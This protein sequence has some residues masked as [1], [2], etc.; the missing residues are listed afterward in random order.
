M[1][2]LDDLEKASGTTW[3]HVRRARAAAIA[4]KAELA[5]AVSELAPADSTVA[6]FGSL[7]RHELTTGSDIDWTLLIDGQANPQHF[8]A[9]LAIERSLEDDLGI[10]PPGRE[11]TFGGLAFSHEILHRIGGSDDSNRNTTQRILLLLESVPIG[12]AS[13]YE[14]VIR[15][16]L[17]RY[18]VEDYGW[19]H[20]SVSVPRFLQNDIARYWRTV[21]IDFAYKRRQRSGSGW[22]LRTVKLRLSRKLTYASGLLVCFAPALN[23]ANHEIDGDDSEAGRTLPLVN[24]LARLTAQTPLERVALAAHALPVIAPHCIELIS[25][26]DDFLKLLDDPEIR[27]HLEELPPDSA[28]N[29]PTYEA[30][31][32]I[33][34]RFQ[35]ALNAIFFDVHDSGIPDLT[36]KYGVF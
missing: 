3:R 35:S 32:E 14:R 5:S 7:A 18:V 24:L 30:A 15:A 22:A 2:R 19:V 25:V 23:F 29:D 26:Y 6:V 27:T 21:A 17:K 1:S 36:R 11:G 4:R 13:A 34:H 16:V 28:D 20:K 10:K 12:D 31:R 8:D 9:A 33:G